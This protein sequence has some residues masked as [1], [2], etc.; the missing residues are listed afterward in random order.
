MS[1]NLELLE[2][3]LEEV[4]KEKAICF[5]KI[6]VTKGET[7]DLLFQKQRALNEKSWALED[8]ITFYKGEIIR[9]DDEIRI[10]RSGNFLENIYWIYLIKTHEKIGHIDYQ[11]YHSNMIEGDIGYYIFPDYRGHNY[12]F[13]ALCLLSDYLKEMGISDFYISV[14][15]DNPASNKIIRKYGG[16]IVKEDNLITTYQCETRK[17]NVLK[18]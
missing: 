14:F 3:K 9:E 8:E 6:S 13:R 4:N 18:H 11:G 10:V 16:I 12:S 1:D 5:H 17:I 2:R 7:R 15:H